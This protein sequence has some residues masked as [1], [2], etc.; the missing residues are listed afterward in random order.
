M[1]QKRH[2]VQHPEKKC[3]APYQP[4]GLNRADKGEEKMKVNLRG[5]EER[6]NIKN[7]VQE[8]EVQQELPSKS[9]SQTAW[10]YSRWS[11]LANYNLI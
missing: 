1:P 7:V 9:N 2:G 4:M 5:K 8:A 6:T 3:W 10:M 11:F